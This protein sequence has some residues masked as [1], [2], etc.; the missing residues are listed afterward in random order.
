MHVGVNRGVPLRQVFLLLD[1][2]LSFFVLARKF[3]CLCHLECV[4]AFL[5]LGVRG[6]QCRSV[7][8]NLCV[9]VAYCVWMWICI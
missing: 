5:C 6:C 9:S 1:L 4:C 3:V 2:L 8:L 7:F